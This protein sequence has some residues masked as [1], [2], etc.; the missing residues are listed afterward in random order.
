[1]VGPKACTRNPDQRALDGTLGNVAELVLACR[2]KPCLVAASEA[3]QIERQEL[4]MRVIVIANALVV[5]L[6][7]VMH[8]AGCSDDV[9]P[10]DEKC[11]NACKVESTLPPACVDIEQ[12]C[13]ADCKALERRRAKS[14]VYPGVR[15]VRRRVIQVRLQDRPPLRHEPR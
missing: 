5:T 12:K 11:A 4:L 6:I 9:N 3:G 8:A 10:I 2:N 13:V 7:L 14:R 15:R 1:M